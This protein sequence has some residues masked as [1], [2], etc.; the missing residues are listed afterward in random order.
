MSCLLA[1]TCEPLTS[2]QISQEKLSAL[3][4]NRDL[5]DLNEDFHVILKDE[6][7]EDTTNPTTNDHPVLE[8]NGDDAGPAELQNSVEEIE[9]LEGL[10]N[11][12]DGNNVQGAIAKHAVSAVEDSV[13]RLCS[14]H[15]EVP[16]PP[17]HN[18]PT[19]ATFH[20]TNVISLDGYDNMNTTKWAWARCFPTLYCP[21]YI[22][23]NSEMR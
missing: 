4:V 14:P 7:I 22:E 17:D 20:Q 13:A 9:T 12:S 18:H 5:I 2:I 3:P 8:I 23:H 1:Q 6:I 19:T 16:T 10:V 11:V 21:S 15:A